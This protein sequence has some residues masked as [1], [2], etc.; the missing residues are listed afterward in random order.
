MPDEC[1]FYEVETKAHESRQIRADRQRDIQIARIPW[2]DHPNH[3]PVDHK[4]A[5][6][7]IGGGRLLKCGGDLTKC[8]LSAAEFEDV[9]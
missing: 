3:S 9:D 6:R 7:V 8:P 4:T 2:C 5:T 1:P